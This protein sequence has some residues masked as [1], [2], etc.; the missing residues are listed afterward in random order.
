MLIVHPISGLVSRLTP[1]AVRA[2]SIPRF[3]ALA[4]ATEASWSEYAASTS[5]SSISLA[6]L[7]S[8]ELADR[9]IR[10]IIFGEQHHQPRLLASEL[11]LVHTL[12]SA[13]SSYRLTLLM[14]HF[15]LLQQP[16]LYSFAQ[17]GDIEA[18]QNE[19]KNSS[20]G[21]RMDSSGY[22]PL[23]QLAGEMDNINSEIIAGFP[24]RLWARRVA[25]EGAAHLRRNE[26]FRN[27]SALDNFNRWSDLEVSQPYAAYIKSSISGK[28]PKLEKDLMQGGLNAAQAFKDAVMAWKIDEQL[29]QIRERQQ[30]DKG[31]VPVQKELLVIICGSGHCEFGFGVTERIR[32]CK[33]AEIL[34]LV[35]KPDDGHYWN[36]EEQPSTES[37]NK[38]A[39]ALIVY[40]S[41]DI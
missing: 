9:N 23:L 2:S 8:A 33:R 10:V 30:V 19:Y 12:A 16:L 15:N 20:E 25:R 28:K 1:I 17:N 37:E 36:V 7:L 26:D 40:E 22:L 32:E 34:L 38:L 3:V 11:L 13:P 29:N 35:A 39:D 27:S 6:D 21:F 14:E 4:N 5:S 18:F 24:P 31:E 41:V